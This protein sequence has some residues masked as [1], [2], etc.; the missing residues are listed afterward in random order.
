MRKLL[1]AGVAAIAA[2]TFAPVAHADSGDQSAAE[3]AVQTIYSQVQRR[4]TPSMPP[5]LQSISWS[6]FYPAS[7][8]EGTIHDANPALGGPFQA[9]YTNPQV[10]P[11]KNSP[12]FRASGQW[13]VNLEFC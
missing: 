5:S 8:G 10:G 11:A 13:G 7:G 2:I 1:I 6:R 4:C 3:Q 12:P 9:Y